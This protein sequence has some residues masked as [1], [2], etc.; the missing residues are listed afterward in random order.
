MIEKGAG[1]MYSAA[2]GSG[3]KRKKILTLLF[4][5]VATTAFA[6]EDRIEL[7]SIDKEHSLRKYHPPKVIE[8][9]EYYEIRGK[10]EKGLRN[11]MCQNGCTWDDGRKYDSVT[12]W[13]WTWDYGSD[14]ASQTCSTDDFSVTLEITIRYPKWVRTGEAPQPL[15]DKWDGYMKNLTMHE[16]GHRDRVVDAA[17]EFSRAVARLPRALSC[18]ERDRQVRA[19]S[20]EI[21]A[22]LNT[23]QQEY[24]S[25]TSHG[26]TQGA[27]FP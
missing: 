4:L 18:G 25:D 2:R 11:Q 26:A 13:Y 14:R 19:L 20:S 1:S 6:A 17:A 15:V 22:Q 12:S 23:A 21:M 24:D 7:A 5:F 8:K 10:S 3:M 16:Q 9:N 27:L